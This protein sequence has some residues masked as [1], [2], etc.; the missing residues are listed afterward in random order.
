M[1]KDSIHRTLKE[2]RALSEAARVLVVNKGTISR[3]LTG[4]RPARKAG[5]LLER[6]EA[7]TR[8]IVAEKTRRDRR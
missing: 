3:F 2:H 4:K 8:K 5:D 6:L 7:V 1:T